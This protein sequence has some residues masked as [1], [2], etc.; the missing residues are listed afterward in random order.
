MLANKIQPDQDSFNALFQCSARAG[1]L[2]AAFNGLQRMKEMQLPLLGIHYCGLIKTYA[3]ACQLEALPERLQQKFKKDAWNLFRQAEEKGFMSLHLLNALLLV[4]VRANDV[5]MM[6]GAVLPLYE[7]LG[8]ELDNISIENIIFAYLQAREFPKL[9]RVWDRLQGNLDLINERSLNTLLEAFVKLRDKEKVMDV[10]E[11]FLQR[12]KE[13]ISRL[14]IVL[15]N[16]AKLPDDLH[17]LLL[18]FETKHGLVKDKMYKWR[19]EPIRREGL[20]EVKLKKI[21]RELYG[22]MQNMDGGYKEVKKDGTKKGR[23]ERYDKMVENMFE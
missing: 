13:P 19:D 20:S 7:K 10:L 4:H 22:K 21:E 16:A 11:I 3:G 6:E 14:L 5:Q 23:F 18:R 8:I 17:G 1:D 15:G 9:I 12:K 2:K